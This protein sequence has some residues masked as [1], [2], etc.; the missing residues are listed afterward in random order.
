MGY[1]SE[2]HQESPYQGEPEPDTLP[3]PEPAGEEPQQEPAPVDPAPLDDTAAR[4][5][6]EAAE[7]QRKR[8]WDAAQA[9]KR[10]EELL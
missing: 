5:A 2:L 1:F 7:A 3:A 4:Q 10:A 8:E 9:K 6:H